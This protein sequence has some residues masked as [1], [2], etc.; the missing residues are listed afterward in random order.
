MKM[1]GTKSIISRIAHN[2]T[3]VCG[4]LSQV[5]IPARVVI[6][7]PYGDK[8]KQELSHK[9]TVIEGPEHNVFLR[10]KKAMDIYS[11]DF[12]VRLTGDCVWIPSRVISKH[13]RDA[14][15]YQAD[16][17]SNVIIRTFMEGYDCEVLSTELFIWLMQQN[18]KAH[19]SEHVT[20]YIYEK[21]MQNELPKDFKVH[22]VLNEYDNSDIKTSID[23]PEEYAEACD[24]WEAYKRKKT[25]A[26]M[27]GSASN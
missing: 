12:L 11:P 4:W 24:L 9:Y 18:L 1:L 15:K 21:I 26:L 22:T 7:V 3:R 6:L 27:I 20:S 5:K 14:I 16:Y 19:H 2:A 25:E 13:I 23:T 8:I 10:F 17:T